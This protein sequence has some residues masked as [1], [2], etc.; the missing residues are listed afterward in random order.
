M[1]WV[2]IQPNVKY[3]MV[4]GGMRWVLIQPNVKYEMGYSPG[5]DGKPKEIIVRCEYCEPI[6]DEEK[7]NVNHFAWCEAGMLKHFIG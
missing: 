6:F 5:E 2:L 4:P 1:R 7:M 3:E